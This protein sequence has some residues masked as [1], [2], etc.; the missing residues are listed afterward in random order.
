MVG[1]GVCFV[2]SDASNEREDSSAYQRRKES[3]SQTQQQLNA[4]SVCQPFP[5]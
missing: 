3:V 5:T 4:N 2:I 1:K